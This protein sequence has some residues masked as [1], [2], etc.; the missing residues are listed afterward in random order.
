MSNSGDDLLTGPLVGIVLGFPIFIGIAIL[1]VP[2]IIISCITGIPMNIL[3]QNM[4]IFAIAAFLVWSFSK[5]QIIENGI[6]GLI[7]GSSVHTYFQWHSV[8]CILIGAAVVGLLF[9][10]S[11]INIGF[12]IKTILFSAVVTFIVFGIL[13]SDA[14]LF[15]LPDT[16]WKIAFVIIFFLENIFIRCS[17]AY[18]SRGLLLSRN[19]NLQTEIH[20]DVR[21]NQNE[22]ATALSGG[23]ADQ[24]NSS[25]ISEI[26]NFVKNMNAEILGKQESEESKDYLMERVYLFSLKKSFWDG[27]LINNME[28]KVYS[29]IKNF[30]DKEYLILPHVSFREIFWWGDWKSDQKLT[31]R[32]TKMHFDFGIY[33][34]ELQ[35]IFFLEVQGKEHKENPKVIERDK[36]KA[37]IMKRCGMKLITMDCSESMTDSE[38]REN[39]VACI[40]KEVPDRK[41]QAAYC[42]NCKNHGKNSLMIIKRNKSDGTYFYGCSTYEE[43]RKDNCPTLNLEDVPPLY[44]GMPL[45]QDKDK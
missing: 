4:A 39:V 1:S 15:P 13:Y 7:V 35:P 8:V 10:I 37:E 33:N 31:D 22:L 11:N 21:G 42:P 6:V 44:W 5:H 30:I 34:E 27:K 29:E 43:S 17:V 45:F 41:A 38:I 16:I 19:G 25:T 9:L 14:G 32:V 26:N 12:W 24:A 40:K 28:E 36:F 2:F 18:S 23:N 20:Y 3:I